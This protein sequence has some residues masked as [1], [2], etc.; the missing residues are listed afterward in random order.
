M[1][2]FRPRVSQGYRKFRMLAL[3]EFLRF[4]SIKALDELT[5]SEN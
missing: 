2:K 4:F 1:R 3:A 5:T